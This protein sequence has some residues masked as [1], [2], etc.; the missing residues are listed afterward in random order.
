M[1]DLP[2]SLRMNGKSFPDEIEEMW[3]ET[4]LD[5]MNC[6]LSE[7]GVRDC[8]A[9]LNTHQPISLAVNGK[10]MPFELFNRL[11][12]RT[13]LVV[14]TV[15]CDAKPALTAQARPQDG[16]VFGEFPPRHEL[17]KYTKFPMVIPT[18]PGYN[19]VYDDAFLEKKAEEA[20]PFPAYSSLLDRAVTDPKVKGYCHLLAEYLVDA[21]QESPKTGGGNGG[22]T[23]LYGLQRP[24]LDTISVIR[25]SNMNEIVP[26]LLPFL[27]TNAQNSVCV[28]T[29][30]LTNIE[31]LRNF[32]IKSELQTDDDFEEWCATAKPW[33]IIKKEFDE[34]PLV[35]QY[36]SVLMPC[37]HVKSTRSNDTEFLDFMKKS[38]KWLRLA[39]QAETV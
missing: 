31:H 16:E 37:G 25:G 11:F 38:K 23:V 1:D 6:D 39:P 36:L 32:D 10:D 33:N 22:R 26:R 2:I 27:L 15:G 12:E 14:Y 35:G 7:N 24:P 17:S 34:F 29:T 8:A 3:R 18:P 30:K 21:C 20:F 9:W 4:Y 19:T 5:V 28:S 13:A